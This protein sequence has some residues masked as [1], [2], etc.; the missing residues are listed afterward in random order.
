AA[1]VAITTN[2]MP[3]VKYLSA[4]NT[5]M[6]EFRAAELQHVLTEKPENMARYDR[7]LTKHL[8]RV[9]ERQAAY[10]PLISSEKE[11]TIYEA[12]KT[13][14]AEYLELNMSI[15]QLSRANKDAEAMEIHRG[16]AQKNFDEAVARLG[17]LIELNSQGAEDAVIAV[18]AAYS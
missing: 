14:W 16:P 13:Q 3:S 17:E 6:S 2:W 12:F 10:E 4:M 8:D 5:D 18:Q 11:R 9:R 7:E 1:T 15:I